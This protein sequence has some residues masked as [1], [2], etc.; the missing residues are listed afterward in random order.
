M[1]NRTPDEKVHLLIITGPVGVGKT[2]VGDEVFEILK[3]E[4]QPI[5]LVNLDELGYVYP[6]AADDPYG[7]HI[8]LKNLGVIWTN[9]VELGAKRLI[10]PYV[11]ETLKGIERFHKIIPH[12]HITTVRLDATVATL[13]QRLSNRPMGGS[14]EWHLNRAV[15]LVSVFERSQ[16]GDLVI[17][18]N[19]KTVSEIARE[20]LSGWKCKCAD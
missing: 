4:M 3:S 18:T 19:D 12:A 15:E 6:K 10:I 16:I 7:T 9:Y 2:A 8:G 17:D 14:L 1:A 11:V 20:I 5:S 13:H